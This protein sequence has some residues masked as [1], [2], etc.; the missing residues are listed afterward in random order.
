MLDDAEPAFDYDACESGLADMLPKRRVFPE[1][2]TE[3]A[4]R[5]LNCPQKKVWRYQEEHAYRKEQE[6]AREFNDN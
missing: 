3:R 2:H 5:T 1:L 6:D 4:A